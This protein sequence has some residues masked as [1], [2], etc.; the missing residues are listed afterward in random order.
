MP[1]GRDSEFKRGIFRMAR[2][3]ELEV[4][5]SLDTTVLFTSLFASFTSLFTGD[6]SSRLRLPRNVPES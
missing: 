2:N 4:S 3:R 5:V 1:Q 6:E